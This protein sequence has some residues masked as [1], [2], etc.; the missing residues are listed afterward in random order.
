MKLLSFNEWRLFEEANYSYANL[1][2]PGIKDSGFIKTGRHTLEDYVYNLNYNV[3]SPLS[4]DKGGVLDNGFALAVFFNP[5]SFGSG[6]S[7]C[8]TG[9][10]YA[11]FE[12]MLSLKFQ[13]SADTQVPVVFVLQDTNSEMKFEGIPSVINNETLDYTSIAVNDVYIQAFGPNL[14]PDHASASAWTAVI[15]K[16]LSGPVQSSNIEK[17]TKFG[18]GLLINRKSFGGSCILDHEKVM[19]GIVSKMFG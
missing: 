2:T 19:A 5:V 12:K 13:P 11:E 1:M 9:D 17:M 18:R 10:L 8:K 14:D 7:S 6:K 15:E 3:V 4:E 16:K